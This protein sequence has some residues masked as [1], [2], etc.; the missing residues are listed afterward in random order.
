MSADLSTFLSRLSDQQKK[1]HR[2]AFLH[3]LKCLTASSE[4]V[5]AKCRDGRTFDAVFHTATPFAG[6]DFRVCLKVAIAKVSFL[7][8]HLLPFATANKVTRLLL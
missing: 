3:H 2:E 1:T 7:L 8:L 4:S 5:T 6:K